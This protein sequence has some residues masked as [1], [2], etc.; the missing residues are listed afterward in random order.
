MST[1]CY[2]VK[3]HGTRYYVAETSDNGRVE[4]F[5]RTNLIRLTELAKTRAIIKTTDCTVILVPYEV[6]R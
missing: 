1:R 3:K 2:I 4:P 6:E 5:R